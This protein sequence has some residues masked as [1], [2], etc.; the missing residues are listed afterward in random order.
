MNERIKILSLDFIYVYL[1]ISFVSIS[2][3]FS[4]YFCILAVLESLRQ[5]K[6]VKVICI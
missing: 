4:S 3:F 2:F 6:Y 5:N 1:Q